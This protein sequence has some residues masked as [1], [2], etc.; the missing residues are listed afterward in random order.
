M[1]SQNIAV[2]WDMNTHGLGSILPGENQRV[3]ANGITVSVT[4]DLALPDSDCKPDS[5]P[6]HCTPNVIWG[7]SK[8]FVQGI[9]VHRANDRRACG[10]K[11]VQMPRRVF[12]G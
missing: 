11:T 1:P 2:T 7:S 9:G 3:F 5:P 4:G 6:I 12:A 10:A 8:V